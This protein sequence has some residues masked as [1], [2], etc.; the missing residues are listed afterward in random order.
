[1]SALQYYVYYKADP[2]RFEELHALVEALFCEVEAATGVRGKWQ[3]R[4]DDASTFMEIYADVASGETFDR[5]LDAAL[6]KVGFSRLVS[7]R[8]TEIFQCA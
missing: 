2:A 7:A 5:A 8:V 6:A 1:M 4:R 3:G